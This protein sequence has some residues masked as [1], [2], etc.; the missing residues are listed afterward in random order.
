M[1]L[2]LF[3]TLSLCG[4]VSAAVAQSSRPLTGFGIEANVFE[5]KVLK[6]TEKFHLPIPELS[7]GVDLNLQWKTHGRKEWQQRRRFPLVGLGFTY[8]NYGIDSVYGRCLSIYPNIQ[9]QL[10][11]W[12]NLEWTMRL[13]NGIAYVTGKYSRFPF[14]TLNNAIGSHINDYPSFNTDIR[15]HINRH[16]D[17]QVGGN[18]TH[19]S[20]ASYHQPNLGINLYGLHAGIKYFPVS[21]SPECIKR[22]IKHLPD[23]WLVQ[24]RVSA[25]LTGSNAPLGPVYP[26]YLATGYVSKRWISKNKAFVGVDYSYHTNIY[27]YLRNNE[28][29]VPLGKES[30]YAYKS[31]VFLGNEFMLG[32]LGVVLQLGFY[33]HQA[34]QTQGK[35][36]QK[37][38]GNYYLVQREKGPL[39]EMFLCGYLKTH[40]GTAELA[41]FGIGFGL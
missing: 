21:S 7:T 2:R 34:F 22:E 38:G 39:K 1:L 3:S 13:G 17:V 9:I 14:D 11:C 4:L 15:Y 16:W 41:E 5:G 25:A 27:T 19:I 23:R 30:Q 32:R 26:I 8:T 35:V 20:D 40:L 6:H 29:F 36:Y 24:L 31:A 18:F 12:K 10:L 28:G 37:L 33:I